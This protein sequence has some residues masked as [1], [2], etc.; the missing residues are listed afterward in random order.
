MTTNLVKGNTRIA[1]VWTEVPS[2]LSACLRRLQEEHAVELLIISDLANRPST[3]RRAFADSVYGWMPRYHAI[4]HGDYRY[5]LRAM[6]RIIGE[7]RPDSLLLAFQW[8][9]PESYAIAWDAKRD[10]VPVIGAMDNQWFGRPG[11]HILSG[12]NRWTGLMPL[13][14]IW[15]PGERAAQY[16]RRLF[17]AKTMILRGMYCADDCLFQPLSDDD[18]V[19]RSERARSFLFVG[20]LSPEKGILDLVEAYRRY[21]ARS[22]NN[23]WNLAIVGDGP[24]RPE[25][26]LMDGLSMH[27]FLQP[28]QVSAI[29]R[30]SDVYVMPSRKEAW[31][32]GLHEAML[33]GLPVVCSDACGASVE[34]VQDG[35]NGFVYRAGD[36][37]ALADC[38]REITVKTRSLADM[39][40]NSRMLATRYSTKQ[41]SASLLH[42]IARLRGSSRN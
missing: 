36:I 2:Y 9:Y 37:D 26:E 18:S 8:R 17:G 14:A 27:G 39:C 15:V 42:A 38:L 11:Q 6:R 16:A 5:R 4:Q 30:S 1:V 35:F 12:L 31:G 22:G 19:P 41:W 32:V 23:A 34:L 24:L 40:Q 29:M 25:I 10:R 21:R 28:T 33:S 13:D 20:R 3:S 7:F